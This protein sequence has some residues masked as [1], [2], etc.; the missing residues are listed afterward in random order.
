MEVMVSEIT[1]NDLREVLGEKIMQVANLEL[2]VKALQ[3]DLSA[4]QASACDCDKGKA[5][6]P[7][8]G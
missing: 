8:K 4:A 6:K 7:S 1:G 3:R 5:K 2:S